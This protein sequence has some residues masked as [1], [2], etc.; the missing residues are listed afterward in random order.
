[1]YTLLVDGTISL[2]FVEPVASGLDLYSGGDINRTDGA[3]EPCL[4]D[5][6]LHNLKLV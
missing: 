3:D 6:K 5:F 2:V 4:V 1:M